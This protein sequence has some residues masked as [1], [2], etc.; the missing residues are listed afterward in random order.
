MS[1]NDFVFDP[2]VDGSVRSCRLYPVPVSRHYTGWRAANVDFAAH[3]IVR[4]CKSNCRRL[5]Q[6]PLVGPSVRAVSFPFSPPTIQWS[7]SP[8]LIPHLETNNLAR[9]LRSFRLVPLR[10]HPRLFTGY[11]TPEGRR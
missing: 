10:F 7:P 11:N 3:H 8:Y 6:F 2:N 5:G 4:C 1:Q 9:S